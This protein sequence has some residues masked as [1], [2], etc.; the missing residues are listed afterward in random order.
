[1]VESTHLQDV[2][3]ACPSTQCVREC[4]YDAIAC[5]N[6]LIYANMPQFMQGWTQANAALYFHWT[7]LYAF[8]LMIFEYFSFLHLLVGRI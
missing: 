3:V 1:M 5:P 8:G 7:V 2:L 4:K 6:M